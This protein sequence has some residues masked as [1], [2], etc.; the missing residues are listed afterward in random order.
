MTKMTE[1]MKKAVGVVEAATRRDRRALEMEFLDDRAAFY[2]KY[3][4]HL[5][6]LPDEDKKALR[7]SP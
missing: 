3:E 4:E 2:R 5:R 6:K 7:G 1:L